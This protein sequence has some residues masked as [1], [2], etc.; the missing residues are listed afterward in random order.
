MP[1]P[2]SCAR[3]N[4]PLPDPALY[5]PACGQVSLDGTLSWDSW[6]PSPDES[7]AP[8][9]KLK[10]WDGAPKPYGI[11][12]VARG[13]G[14][15]LERLRIE[16]LAEDPL[17]A[18]ALP[19]VG[20]V[21][22]SAMPAVVSISLEHPESLLPGSPVLRR[23]SNQRPP[24]LTVLGALC[25]SAFRRIAPQRP[26]GAAQAGK[27]LLQ[28]HVLV[29]NRGGAVAFEQIMIRLPRLSGSEVGTSV[30]T[31]LMAGGVLDSGEVACLPVR[32]DVAVYDA[33]KVQIEM[34]RGAQLVLGELKV[35]LL[36][37]RGGAPAIRLHLRDTKRAGVPFV[38]AGISGR[39]ARIGVALENQSAEQLQVT[40]VSV[41]RSPDDTWVPIPV[42]RR[43]KQHRLEPGRF[44][45]GELR[46]VLTSTFRDA[47]GQIPSGPLVLETKVE[48]RAD[49]GGGLVEAVGKFSMEVKVPVPLVGR[50]AIDFG[51]AETAAAAS[52]SELDPNLSPESPP[53]V[54]ELGPVGLTSEQ[55]AGLSAE[56]D[57]LDV[58][59]PIHAVR[60]LETTLALDREGNWSVGEDIPDD[61]EL[62]R[63]SRFK[64]L[65]DR[66][67]QNRP[68]GRVEDILAA[69]NEPDV[70]ERVT[71]QLL[72]GAFLEEVRKLIEE[73]PE[74]A[75][76]CSSSVK[77]A[78]NSLC[79]VYA[80]HPARMGDAM[81]RAFLEG[82]SRAGLRQVS[83]S[84]PA[85]ALILESWPPALTVS[86][87]IGDVFAPIT[88]SGRGFY[89]NPI[90]DDTKER[91]LVIDVGGG[92]ADLSAIGVEATIFET[93]V[94]I[95]ENTM[96]T[97]FTGDGFE[98]VITEALKIFLKKSPRWPM[99]APVEEQRDAYELV[100][101]L[102]HSDGPLQ[103]L[104]NADVLFHPDS[105]TVDEVE[106][107]IKEA[108]FRKDSN[109]EAVA[110]A[111]FERGPRSRHLQIRFRDLPALAAQIERHFHHE[112]WDHLK[113]L[114]DELKPLLSQDAD[115]TKLRLV[116]SGRGAA[117]PLAE[118]LIYRLVEQELSLRGKDRT[119]FLTPPASKSITSW[120]ALRLIDH[121]ASAHGH[122]LRRPDEM[123]G[124]SVLKGV[125]RRKKKHLQPMDCRK[126]WLYQTP[127]GSTSSLVEDARLGPPLAV[128][129]VAL[130]RADKAVTKRK[131]RILV[132][133][134]R[135]DGDWEPTLEAELDFLDEPLDRQWIFLRR[136]GHELVKGIVSAEDEATALGLILEDLG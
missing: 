132:Y 93:T 35:P 48:A 82:F 120:G 111:L 3:C 87:G 28:A 81:A 34:A 56:S 84:R 18:V 46:P 106:I 79:K 128:E 104:T 123:E 97:S 130:L 36:I 31:N 80:T 83:A 5:C 114:I 10:L 24:D 78:G 39:R 16:A 99:N 94:S 33:L 44:L 101:W 125:D 117:C 70:T 108:L 98:R 38:G 8:A 86:E 105:T 71:P 134:G 69:W 21:T 76:E 126:L 77:E 27:D 122:V 131:G 2:R 50:L 133:S 49:D 118:A 100:K 32:I 96:S 72:I 121:A 1:E 66:P 110:E 124:F 67:A 53:I 20:I 11:D 55:A 12:V 102:Q 65:A 14:E 92:S 60:F 51:T 13:D 25:L 89:T 85:E 41:R 74:V 113:T 136:R 17:T 119:I 15:E 109:R 9:V 75:A 64:W 59:D 7:V 73:H 57:R 115:D 112:F 42:P 68:L 58:S 52:L 95:L 88:L 127:D 19:N 47:G 43:W 23:A 29:R 90:E 22:M 116:I 63:F 4:E 54:I 26:G 6:K 62:R 107:R 103:V 135:S 61:I 129:S 30:D 45:S 40:Q 91:L 37:V